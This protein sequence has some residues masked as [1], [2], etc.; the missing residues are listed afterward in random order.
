MAYAFPG[1]GALDYF[2]CRYGRSKL[3]FR[4]P[5]RRLDAPYCA[6]IGGTETYGKFVAEPYPALVER[7]IGLRMVNLGC[8][9]AGPDVFLNEPAVFDIVAGAQVCVV[10]VMGALNLSNRFYAVHPR[11]N[12][13]FLRAAPELQELFPE[14]DFTEFHF[15]RHLLRTLRMAGAARFD[16]VAEELRQVWVARM[17]ELLGSLPG[18]VVLLWLSDH[19]PMRSGRPSER[20]R[21][22]VLVNAEMIAAVRH[23]VSDYV[24]V[25]YSPSAT[26][27]EQAGLAF[28]PMDRLAAAEV[29]GPMAHA[30]IAAA[31]AP[32]LQSRP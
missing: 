16:A 4:G 31:L 7:Q 2:P 28:A 17:A 21:D 14:L 30:E 24:E 13:R 11:R 15:T 23:L 32:V 6:V 9:N 22:P 19:A 26:A 29:P 27:G 10:Q 1:A 5:Q 18:K 25:V 20:L 3:L 8:V 12:D